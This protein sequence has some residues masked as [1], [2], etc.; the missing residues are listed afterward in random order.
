MEVN[1]YQ[2]IKIILRIYLKVNITIVIQASIQKINDDELLEYLN[3]Q[4]ERKLWSQKGY[5]SVQY[6]LI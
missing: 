4:I 2:T 3:E 5:G 6:F 1:T